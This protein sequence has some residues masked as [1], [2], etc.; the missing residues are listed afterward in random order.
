MKRLYCLLFGHRWL[1]NAHTRLT[2]APDEEIV[3]VIVRTCGRCGKHEEWE[4]RG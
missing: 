4:E 2:D 1:T 3:F